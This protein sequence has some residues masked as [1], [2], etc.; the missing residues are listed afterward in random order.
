M[1]E[2]KQQMLNV[3]LSGN[4]P[5]GLWRHHLSETKK[6]KEKKRIRVQATAGEISFLGQFLFFRGARIGRSLLQFPSGL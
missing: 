5:G 4:S 1:F 2:L 3:H 6:K